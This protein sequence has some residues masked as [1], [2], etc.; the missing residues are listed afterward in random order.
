MVSSDLCFVLL[1]LVSN[2]A[3]APFEDGHRHYFTY[4]SKSQV[5]GLH[6]LSTII[7]FHVTPVNQSEDGS[8]NLL[9][10]DSFVQHSDKGYVDN[11]P[12]HWD[13]TRNFLFH[14]GGDGAVTQIFHHPEEDHEV[15]TLKKLL[16][17]TLSMYKKDS[18]KTTWTYSDWETD[19][20]G[21]LL[22]TYYGKRLP[23]GSMVSRRHEST[24]E[25][26]RQ[27]EKTIEYDRKGR[28]Q[29]VKCTDTI[30]LRDEP[31]PSQSSAQTGEVIIVSPDT[32]FPSL[33]STAN[34]VVKL[35]ARRRMSP[36]SG[37]L[38]SEFKED[39]PQVTAPAP[40]E[41]ALEEVKTKFH[42]LLDCIESY[43]DK[44]AANRTVCV[45]DLMHLFNNLTETDRVALGHQYLAKCTTN[46]S[47][48]RDER[49]L[50][51]DI[52]CRRGDEDSQKLV[53]QYV[54]N[55]K[56]ATEEDLRRPLFHYVVLTEPILETIKS[57]EQLCFVG[58]YDH[59]PTLEMTL[60]QKRACLTLGALARSLAD[61]GNDAAA[62]DVL[63]KLENKLGFYNNTLSSPIL[64]RK[65]RSIHD[66]DHEQ[67]HH[68][69]SKMVLLHSL[70][71]AGMPRSLRHI[72]SYLQPNVGS[73]TWR[74]AAANS[75]RQ[76]TCNESALALFDI[77]AHEE[78]EKVH[79]EAREV[80]LKHPQ[81]QGL[82]RDKE[83]ILLSRDYTFHSVSRVRR[84]IFH[85]DFSDGI[86]L[87]IKVP[88][89]QYDKTFGTN[90]IGASL[91]LRMINMLDLKLH[92]LHSF[93]K[94]DVD[95]AAWV[96]A[97][98]GV[99]GKH[100]DI[101]RASLCYAGHINY[102]LNILKD[103]DINHFKDLLQKLDDIFHSIVDGIKDAIDMFKKITR[104][105]YI[106]DMLTE[107]IN[108]VKGLPDLV[109]QFV[110]DFVMLVKKVI[111]YHTDPIMEKVK[112]IAQRVK[113]FAEEIKQD[114]LEFYHSIADAVVITLPEV[115]K[116]LKE[117]GD[118]I[119]AVFKDFFKSPAQSFSKLGL[120][121]LRVRLA[122]TMVIDAKNRIVDACAFMKGTSPFWMHID[123]EVTGIT[124]DIKD[125]VDMVEEKVNMTIH[126]QLSGPDGIM[127][128]Y[129]MKQWFHNESRVLLAIVTD[130]LSKVRTMA[131]PFFKA[132]SDVMTVVKGVK[133]AYETVKEVISV[134]KSLVQKIFGSKFHRRFPAERDSG[135]CTD[136]VWPSTGGNKYH[137]IGVDV[138]ARRG[139]T[140]VNPVAGLVNATGRDEITITPTDDNFIEY[141]IV[142]NNVVPNK[143]VRDS[144][145]VMDSGE[146]I[147][148]AGDTRCVPN[149]IH[150]ALR[151]T[152]TG[153]YADPSKY[154]DRLLPIPHW[155]QECNEHIFKYIGKT[156]E[157]NGITDGPP[158][159]SEDPY[160]GAHFPKMT[161]AAH[162]Q[163]DTSPP[164]KPAGVN[165]PSA[166]SLAPSFSKLV[167]PLKNFGLMLKAIKIPS[168]QSVFN[169]N[170]LS[171]S[172]LKD[173]LK[174]RSDIVK[175]IDELVSDV[176]QCLKSKPV[177][178]PMS[179]S[180]FK[181]H[182]L[183]TLNKIP[184]IG[185]KAEMLASLITN[186]LD[187]CPNLKA[188]M[189]FAFGHLCTPDP[190]CHG[191]TCGL[192][193]PYSHYVKSVKVHIRTCGSTLNLT[194]PGMKHVQDTHG[195]V[196]IH[197]PLLDDVVEG[198][199]IVFQ[200][201]TAQDGKDL[202]ANLTGS[203]C[204]T[205]FGS[206]LPAVGI[207]RGA[208]FHNPM[209]T[210]VKLNA[211]LEFQVETMPV[212][213]WMSKMSQCHLDIPK[214]VGL[215]ND[216]RGGILHELFDSKK[217]FME[218]LQQEFKVKK[219]SCARK[220]IP[221]KSIDMTFFAVRNR[222]M[223]GPIP[224]NLGFG[225]GGSVGVEIALGACFMSMSLEA[226]VTPSA[227]L[228][229]WGSLGVDIGF[230]YGGIK[231][232]G[233]IMQTKFPVIGGLR[234]S[235]FPL[236]VT[237]KMDMEMVPLTLELSA[238]AKI[239][240]I[241]TTKTV[242]RGRLWHY[243][244]PTIRRNIF[245]HPYKG[246]D[247]SPPTFSKNAVGTRNRR[248]TGSGGCEVKQLKGRSPSDTAF[249]LKVTTYDDVSDV[250]VDYAIGTYSGGT[251]VVDWTEMSGNT[252]TMPAK[253]TQGIPLYWTVRA[254][255]SEGGEALTQCMLHTYD[256]TPPDGRVDEDFRISSNPFE[257]GGTV[258]VLDD[259]VVDPQQEIALGFGPGAQGYEI[260]SWEPVSLE[261]T[262]MR[263]GE[264]TDLKYFSL[265]NTG[266]L[267][268]KPMKTLTTRFDY[269]CAKQCIAFGQNCV[270]F[271]FEYNL[272]TCDLHSVSEG[273]S[274]ALRFKGN[275]K[276]FERLGVGQNHYKIFKNL[277][278]TH[279][280]TYFMNTH[281]TN[282]L[283]YESHLTSHGTLIDLT[284]PSPGP[285]GNSTRD[286]TT[287]DG[288]SASIL[289][290]CKEL[291]KLPNHRKI[292]DGAD[293]ETVF[294]G[295]KRLF[296][297][298]YT[299]SNN[300]IGGNWDGFH[301]NETDIYGYTWAAGTSVCSNNVVDYNDPHAK[302]PNRNEWT[303]SGLTSGLHLSDG[304]H[305]VTV[306][307]VNNIIHGGA[308]VTTVCHSTPLIVDTTP[309]I[310][311][312]IDD[313]FFDGDFELLGLYFNGSDPLSKIAHVHVGLGLTRND[314]SLRPY[315]EYKSYAN[316]KQYVLVD[317][318]V[319]EPGVAAWPRIRLTNNVGL[320]TSGHANE[321][322]VVDNTPPVAGV[323]SDGAI[324][325]TDMDYQAQADTI[326]A[327]WKDFFDPE[328][329][330][331]TYMWGV[332]TKPGRDDIVK[333]RDEDRIIHDD[334]AT[335]SLSH[336]TT[337]Y[338]TIVAFNG[339]LNMMR[340]NTTSNG[341][342]VDLTD[343]VKGWIKDGDN[344]TL[345]VSYTS[346]AALIQ[347]VWGGFSDPESGIVKYEVDIYI[348]NQHRKTNTILANQDDQLHYMNEKTL[349]LKHG[350]NVH[351]KVRGFNGAGKSVETTTN[352]FI[353]DLTPPVAYFVHDSDGQGGYQLD[354]TGLHLSWRFEDSE[355]GI[356]KYMVSVSQEINGMKK[357]IWPS[358]YD[359][360]EAT[361][362][363]STQ[364]SYHVPLALRDGTR[365]I[366][367]VIAVNKAGLSKT[368]DSPGI[369]IDSTPP[370]IQQIH[371][372]P[373]KEDE[374]IENQALIHTDHSKMTISWRA[375]DPESG[376]SEA[377]VALGTSEHDQ[378]ITKGFLT[379]KHTSEVTLKHLNLVDFKTGGKYY[380]FQIK[381]KNGAGVESPVSVSMRINV[382]PGNVPGIIYDGRKR[383]V[384][385]DFLHDK[386]TFAMSFAGFQSIA[387]GI[388][389]YEWG[390]G[391]EPYVTDIVPFTSFGIVKT[392]ESSG[393]GQIDIQLFE[394]VKYFTTVRARTG[395]GGHEEHIVSTS[396]GILVDT[397]GPTIKASNSKGHTIPDVKSWG[398]VFQK[399]TD[400]VE[401]TPDITDP[402]GVNVSHVCLGSYP[403]EDD[404]HK[405][406]PQNEKSVK[407][408]SLEQ[409]ASV[410]IT[411]EATDNAENSVTWESIALIPDST[412]PELVNFTCTN[413]ISSMRSGIECTWAEAREHESHI[414]SI[415]MCIGVSD[416]PCS[417]SPFEN[418][419]LQV[420][421]WKT[422]IFRVIKGI[423]GQKIFVTAYIEN[424]MKRKTVLTREV[425]IDTTIPTGGNVMIVTDDRLH[426]SRTSKQCQVPQSFVEVIIT[427]FKDADTG[428][429]RCEIGLGRQPGSTDIH[430]MMEAEQD[431]IIF[432]GGL[433]LQPEDKV[434]ATAKC[435]NMAG[436][437]A[438]A[439]SQAVVV[440]PLPHLS[441]T[442]GPE[443]NDAEFLTG[444][445]TIEGHWHYTS[446]CP[447]IKAEWKVLTV[448]W[449][450]F[451]DFIP[452]SES[453]GTFYNDELQ[454]TAGFTYINV[455]RVTDAIGR[456]HVAYSNGVTVRIQPPHPGAVRD[457]TGKD[458]DYQTSTTELSANWDPF[459]ILNSKDA[460]QQIERYEVAIG[461]DAK[462]PASRYNVHFFETAH[463]NTSYT[464]K[465][466][467]LTAKLI[468]YYV[469]V[470]AYSKAGSFEE[471]YSDGI[472]VGYD[473][474]ISPG[475]I[476][477]SKYSDS[478]EDLKVSWSGF[479]SDIGLT[480]YT[481]GISKDNIALP[482]NTTTCK[483]LMT[484]I[485]NNYNASFQ[486]A[487]LD[488]VVYIHN[489]TLQQGNSYYV[490]VIAHD[491][492][493]SC[494]GVSQGPVTIDTTPPTQGHVSVQGG[495]S[496]KVVYISSSDMVT[497]QWDGFKDRESGIQRYHLQLYS[498]QPC[499]QQQKKLIKEMDVYNI[500]HTTLYRL[501]LTVTLMYTFT[502]T[503]INGA[504]LNTTAATVPILIDVSRPQAGTV[505]VGRDWHT[506]RTFQSEHDMVVA[507]TA[508]ARDKRAS[509]C[510]RS[511]EIFPKPSGR[512]HWNILARSD[513]SPSSALIDQFARVAVTYDK[514]LQ[515]IIRGGVFLNLEDSLSEGNYTFML[516]SAR[517]QNIITSLHIDF[518]DIETYQTPVLKE[519]PSLDD[520]D[521]PEEAN[522]T[523]NET[524]D[525]LQ[526]LSSPGVVVFFY[527]YADDTHT[528][529]GR[530]CLRDDNKET[531]SWFDL[532]QDPSDYL[533]EISL[534]FKRNIDNV[535]TTWRTTLF[536]EGHRK[537]D[538]EGYA[539]SG[540]PSII[541]RVHNLNEYKP[542]VRDPLHPFF[543][544]SLLS[545]VSVPDTTDKECLHGKPFF[546]GESGIKEIWMG[547]GSNASSVDN[548]IPFQLKSTFCLPCN[549]RCMEVCDPNC[550][551]SNLDTLDVLSLELK[552]IALEHSEK[553]PENNNSDASKLMEYKAPTY[554]I[555]VKAVNFADESTVAISN[556]FQVDITPP[557]FEYMMCVDPQHSLDEPTTFIGSNNSVGAF[558]ECNEDVSE[559]AEYTVQIGSKEGGN[560]ILKAT[561]VGLK[562]KVGLTLEHAI[563]DDGK[564][565]YVTVTAINSAG[566]SA[567][568]TCN[569]TVLVGAP[570]VSSVYTQSLFTSGLTKH[571]V[572]LTPSQHKI[573]LNVHGGN[574]IDYY[575][576]TIGT[577]PSTDDV[578]PVIKVATRSESKIAI[579]EGR[580]MVD[581]RITNISLS[582]YNTNDTDTNTRKAAGSFLV[583]EPGRCYYHSLHGVGLSH[584]SVPVFT[585]PVC[586]RRTG[587][588]LMEFEE[589]YNVEKTHVIHAEPTLDNHNRSLSLSIKGYNGSLLIG[590]LNT[591][592]LSQI[593]GSAASAEYIPYIHDPEE[594]LQSTSR[595][596]YGRL[597]KPL[598]LSFYISPAK[599]ALVEPVLNISAH[600]FIP[601][602]VN[603]S[604]SLLAWN[605]DIQQWHFPDSCSKILP[606]DIAKGKLCLSGQNQV[607]Q[608]TE[609][610]RITEP[611]L[612]SLFEV[613]KQIHNTPPVVLTKTVTAVED[614]PLIEYIDVQDKED[615]IISFSIMAQGK[616]GNASV[617]TD[618]YLIYRPDLN[619][620]GKDIVTIEANEQKVPNP[621]SVVKDILIQVT[622]Q[623]D[624]PELTFI[625][626]NN[627]KYDAETICIEATSSAHTVTRPFL[628]TF[629]IT[630]PDVGKLRLVYDTDAV[631]VLHMQLVE[632]SKSSDQKAMTEFKYNVSLVNSPN[633]RHKSTINFRA[634]NNMTYS[635]M[636]SLNI[637]VVNSTCQGSACD[638]IKTYI[639][640]AAHAE[641]F[642]E[643]HDH[644]K[645][646]A[647]PAQMFRNDFLGKGSIKT[648]GLE[649][650]DISLSREGIFSLTIDTVD[651]TEEFMIVTP[652]GNL[653]LTASEPLTPF[654]QKNILSDRQYRGR[655][656]D[657]LGQPLS[658][659]V[660]P[661]DLKTV[662]VDIKV[663]S[664]HDRNTSIKVFFNDSHGVWH[665]LPDICNKSQTLLLSEDQYI[666]PICP[667]LFGKMNLTQTRN[668]DLSTKLVMLAMENN[669]VNTAPYLEDKVIYIQEGQKLHHQIKA[670]D[671]EGDAFVFHLVNTNRTRGTVHLLATG[672]LD[673][674][675][676]PHFSGVDH[677][678][679]ELVE[680]SVKGFKPNSQSYTLTIMITAVDGPPVLYYLPPD[681]DMFRVDNNDHVELDITRPMPYQTAV[682]DLGYVVAAYWNN[683]DDIGLELTPLNTTLHF[684]A[685]K[686]AA[687]PDSIWSTQLSE[688]REI[689]Q[690]K[691]SQI[692][693]HFL[694]EFK[695]TLMY[696]IKVKGKAA[697]GVQVVLYARVSYEF[698]QPDTVC[699][700]HVSAKKLPTLHNEPHS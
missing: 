422:D 120:S 253:L 180:T 525:V 324:V 467:K 91:G 25:T 90:K 190:D 206:C 393:F 126:P 164:F 58:N 496:T 69:V 687:L 577:V 13:L 83:N 75:L 498:E 628:G 231:L 285:V 312:G 344:E 240:L 613:D 670:K 435:S 473:L 529:K 311:N 216:I 65:K 571:G 568:T 580:L 290:R 471:A 623:D 650:R 598:G 142:I 426:A 576:W 616:Y 514:D 28:I 333:F 232:T 96:T 230:A 56:N 483:S 409:G 478:R 559:I 618:G 157:A 148:T 8:M 92:P 506:S 338:S 531:D 630:D 32:E 159:D 692:T 587:D 652:K 34:C 372:G 408:L 398:L 264:P 221:V 507:E 18:L 452:I 329:G 382:L 196:E 172:K 111:R 558:W 270:S 472:K 173:I 399:E 527:G 99:I 307:A 336:N 158:K 21:R 155:E 424:V 236:D 40:K 131:D 642:V 451:Q 347:A 633:A 181:M 77:L 649:G 453:H 54:L 175:G 208:K 386:S 547:V 291:S 182:M 349:E 306:Q 460:S 141:Q 476:D 3:G 530:I 373:M 694:S 151:V 140:I 366:A 490:T 109:V 637:S 74:R 234:F 64:E 248:S 495:H 475:S 591:T 223:V 536:F 321:P 672:V 362:L 405:C 390:I 101:I 146:A 258:V 224:M 94:I 219:D 421:S 392:N 351:T 654:E 533:Y 134:G 605:K 657:Q 584:V 417:L 166:T 664:D 492:V 578:F 621:H 677:V 195:G 314:V 319:L 127:G 626:A 412:P 316:P 95:N 431:K 588:T 184:A 567:K 696:K 243:S 226:T 112:Q 7:K 461:D 136:A 102:D 632:L 546:D 454:L 512:E 688:I 52:L 595:I 45:Q 599:E 479:Y 463:L 317:D 82:R 212:R 79:K 564:T 114:A 370:K 590:A 150:V 675:P 171:V 41:Q 87:T 645:M 19:Q 474:D 239:R 489:L 63:E 673:Y 560:D 400:I 55:N 70:G 570:A 619:Y 283:G 33:S 117:T 617:T 300:L 93:F 310:F 303:Y 107:I 557:K 84:E 340:V 200:L 295:H 328:S 432:I 364:V 671:A 594:S 574:G 17:G 292:I 187:A 625:T 352:G 629:V 543:A 251:N 103:Y 698:C 497:L 644:D 132:Y 227:S 387:F 249:L 540:K 509:E 653:Q 641:E 78:N 176:A 124:D 49:Y 294:N 491:K 162:V 274:A 345:D 379:F 552:H 604:I 627:E 542:P 177:E 12:K 640:K 156:Y 583:L 585:Q 153:E 327:Q 691:V 394:G 30:T 663:K 16:A 388:V 323:I 638:V 330:I 593:Y 659:S 35:T 4:S 273:P 681:S 678:E 523:S 579:T 191:M 167:S 122:V 98:L 168:I 470:R 502:I 183:L 152:E 242:Y 534:G 161:A 647:P 138:S 252:L 256:N 381:V 477:V 71:N 178:E 438:S 257:L 456:V 565:Y 674:T 508:L 174:A 332:G 128:P 360:Q 189:S 545:Y 468:T 428:I 322:I 503:A 634:T 485:S 57:V 207:I 179:F 284:P 555:S 368:V 511:K 89:F 197:V 539:F 355:S 337:Y 404:I 397:Q 383:F 359:P 535:K 676:R 193:F 2:A 700:D 202:I 218:V 505:K 457:G 346:E 357:T 37:I 556:A 130:R 371:L 233:Y 445:T 549:D 255:N 363:P 50:F 199:H 528:W 501:N 419:V 43:D 581:G 6:N 343:P 411:I 222:F 429:E 149:F 396:D 60:T 320:S 192:V 521:V 668:G 14:V 281:V 378:S 237:A 686:P 538:I 51:L 600:G 185:D 350:D 277:N 229:V 420:R 462:N 418:V 611:L 26:H 59:I 244:T 433:S 582:D 458:K 494:T 607:I 665:E 104:P 129:S 115:G 139:L 517:G 143:Y 259:S 413:D 389:A 198:M 410:F 286:E 699:V 606:I 289:Q 620:C 455:I 469:T 596:L 246:T 403:Y 592:D 466:L 163:P 267:T 440:S 423:H 247:S 22:H 42:D 488:T 81:R 656:V 646:N 341:V 589:H 301:D 541:Y 395:H 308:L 427:G 504:G 612:L 15:V 586:V 5:L 655:L 169:I 154:L 697:E 622:C 603:S 339:A 241:F 119:I 276:S 250:K 447:V 516:V 376:I 443:E 658:I 10:I 29:H 280:E 275:Y 144:G 326:C 689:P 123:E 416:N 288:C 554:Y 9:M 662:H 263:S 562:R 272:Q 487:G 160:M 170:T 500:T 522:A 615:D 245:T 573:G 667:D 135:S 441:V 544:Q 61:M 271:D 72:R 354:K 201:S 510:K 27:H 384:D 484:A 680:A 519:I 73:S 186:G 515:N 205:E 651:A 147:G 365:Y 254:R 296:D 661:Q 261:R 551:V 358:P 309:P 448:S 325:G 116:M 526:C 569:V 203:L 220:V 439:T 279:K 315:E 24:A 369:L 518:S 532:P 695:G 269:E 537:A 614:K 639:L 137:T 100:V 204:S 297:E 436:L 293:G 97:N 660:K 402:S 391:T 513:M 643:H 262:T 88:G 67:H 624:P 335:V 486:S 215:L 401:V 282:E 482:G 425:F 305:Y 85:I 334:C 437:T 561:S 563:M 635:N 380:Y 353:V 217:T 194:A 375:I 268:A 548:V 299:L 434:F 367:R 636:I 601:I 31:A 47:K 125:L 415:R 238:Y 53:L 211:S 608:G 610:I 188:G 48:C 669:L 679:I 566:I 597:I 106:K 287:F 62:E 113:A 133:E 278:L 465:N 449:D 464:F 36:A 118:D 414:Q 108:F 406:S 550:T 23:T 76:Y 683:G 407:G 105:G 304:P 520:N 313:V 298:K 38:M 609:F 39:T 80:Y 442:D 499:L 690:K 430:G 110:D 260:I 331:K 685:A 493:D 145:V 631:K 450:V 342:L 213:M 648:T 68:I 20:H 46:G 459:G 265:P 302:I 682:V 602:N 361:D 684:F 11:N 377:Y 446:G 225:A 318:F 480:E 572:A 121:V 356:E 666:V 553:L 210:P 575:E 1:V 348:N 444:L 693:M 86:R 214:V 44:F 524:D 228:N 209:C 165:N 266:S 235:K 481:V 66:F 385:A 374:E